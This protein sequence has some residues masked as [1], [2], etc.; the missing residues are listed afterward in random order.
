MAQATPM[1]MASVPVP[2]S[3]P[4]L[5]STEAP[6]SEAPAKAPATPIPSSEPLAES[7][8]PVESNEGATMLELALSNHN[9]PVQITPPVG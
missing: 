5:P 3:T 8:P 1:S 4:A 2:T 6:E 9:V 7:K